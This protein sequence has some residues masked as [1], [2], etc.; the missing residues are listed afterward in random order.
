M[1]TSEKVFLHFARLNVVTIGHCN[2]QSQF[3]LPKSCLYPSLCSK[4]ACLF[5]WINKLHCHLA[6]GWFWSVRGTN[7]RLKGQKRKRLGYLF[8]QFALREF[9]G[10]QLP[11]SSQDHSSQKI[12]FSWPSLTGWISPGLLIFSSSC[13]SGQGTVKAPHCYQPYCLIVLHHFCWFP[14]TM[15]SSF[16]LSI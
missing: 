2:K 4:E 7:R 9:T 1:N 6:F 11:P 3:S 5:V 12:T 13:Q 8:C 15:P 16:S 14:L 10:S